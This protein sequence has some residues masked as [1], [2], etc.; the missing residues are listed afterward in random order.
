MSLACATSMRC[1]SPPQTINTTEVMITPNPTVTNT[2]ENTGWPII[3]RMM[4][5]SISRPNATLDTSAPP[6]SAQ[7]LVPSATLMDQARYAI[8]MP[9]SPCAKFSRPVAL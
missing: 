5:R 9:S 7:V 2:P 4:K 8:S 3:L 6:T 1:C